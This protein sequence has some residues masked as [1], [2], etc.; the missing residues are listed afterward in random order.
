MRK[1]KIK[2]TKRNILYLIIGRLTTYIFLYCAMV[3]LFI[4]CSLYIINNCIT[5]LN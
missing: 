4:K 5:T 1:I 3:Q 2:N